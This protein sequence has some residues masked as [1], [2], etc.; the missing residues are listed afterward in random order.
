MVEAFAPVD[1]PTLQTASETDPL[2]PAIIYFLDPNHTTII[3]AVDIELGRT[4]REQQ[5]EDLCFGYLRDIHPNFFLVGPHYIDWAF[6]KSKLAEEPRMDALEFVPYQDGVILRGFAEFKSRKANGIV[7]KMQGISS[8][9]DLLRSDPVLFQDAL[10]SV[11]GDF[12]F[13]KI[14]IPNQDAGLD[15]KYISPAPKQP[16]RE[17]L[18]FNV[19]FHVVPFPERRTI[20]TLEH[21]ELTA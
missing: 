11:G 4:N 13:P 5:Y 2:M 8:T 12:I 10:N 14:Y 15:V 9:L 6:G 18:P 1:L 21:L 16:L 7:R 17:P 20:P 3:K 19:D